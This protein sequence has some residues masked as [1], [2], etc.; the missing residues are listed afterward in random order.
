MSRIARETGLCNKASNSIATTTVVPCLGELSSKYMTTSL[1]QLLSLEISGR[2]AQLVV[3]WVPYPP[4]SRSVEGIFPLGLTFGSDSTPYQLF[5]MRAFTKVYSNS[6]RCESCCVK[7]CS[8][9]NWGESC[10]VKLCS[11]GNWG[12][13]CRVKLFCDR[14]RGGVSHVVETG[15]SHQT[16]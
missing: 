15:V 6:N 7:L 13:S 10:H 8:N 2:T 1:G 3:R 14:K 5:E 12:E 16:V 9:G 4:G 11:N